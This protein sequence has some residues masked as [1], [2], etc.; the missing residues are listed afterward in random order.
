[1]L[2]SPEFPPEEMLGLNPGPPAVTEELLE[3]CLPVD[4]TDEGRQWWHE[5]LC[6]GDEQGFWTRFLA[7]DE[8]ALGGEVGWGGNGV[9][10]EM[11]GGYGGGFEGGL[12]GWEDGMV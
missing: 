12:G 3:A 4:S 9:V 10:E 6:A 1:M 2:I 8:R 5:L 7:S 11:Q